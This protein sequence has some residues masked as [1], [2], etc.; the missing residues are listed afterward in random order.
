M[1]GFKL[2]FLVNVEIRLI[3]SLVCSFLYAVFYPFYIN[4]LYAKYIYFKI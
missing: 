4:Q 3:A 1:L 2:Y